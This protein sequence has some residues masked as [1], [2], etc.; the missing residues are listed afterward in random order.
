MP[1]TLHSQPITQKEIKKLVKAIEKKFNVKMEYMQGESWFKSKHL[2]VAFYCNPVLEVDIVEIVDMSLLDKFKSFFFI[3][4]KPKSINII[5]FIAE[6]IG[7][8]YV[9]Y[10]ATIKEDKFYNFKPNN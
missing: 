5:E 9:E 2:E 6:Q 7:G 10:N 4:T 1:I 3:F 8:Y